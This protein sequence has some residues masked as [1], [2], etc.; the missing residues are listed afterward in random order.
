MKQPLPLLPLLLAALVL[1]AEPAQALT[2]SLDKSPYVTLAVYEGDGGGSGGGGTYFFVVQEEAVNGGTGGGSGVNAS[3]SA[4]SGSGSDS[5]GDGGAGGGNRS[6]RAQLLL[7][8]GAAGGYGDDPHQA[9]EGHQRD[10]FFVFDPDVADGGKNFDVAIPAVSAA[11]SSSVGGI[12]N[13]GGRPRRRQQQQ[14]QLGHRQLLDGTAN[15]GDAKPIGYVLARRCP[16]TWWYDKARTGGSSSHQQHYYCPADKTHCYVQRSYDSVPPQPLC[17]S[18]EKKLSS[19]TQTIWPVV[20]VWYVLLATCL[21]CTTPGRN[22]LDCALAAVLPC[23]NDVVIKIML[24]RNPDRASYLVRRFYWRNRERIEQR[25][26]DMMSAQQDRGGGRRDNAGGG[27]GNGNV[28]DMTTTPQPQQQNPTELRLR[29]RI[30]RDADLASTAA[31]ADAVSSPSSPAGSEGEPA[32]TGDN[33]DA[34]FSSGADGDDSAQ[35]PPPPTEIE[36][37]ADTDK[38]PLSLS[39]SPAAAAAHAAERQV[40]G[41]DAADSEDLTEG[42]AGLACT[43]CFVP[44]EDGDRVGAL[45]CNH[46]VSVWKRIRRKL[47]FRF[48]LLYCHLPGS[49]AGY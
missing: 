4:I 29:T 31:A 9:E 42:A 32:V 47:P 45:P 3:G 1:K 48:L 38:K 17:L 2:C 19:V 33:G 41:V 35:S 12:N 6:R 13:G 15:D 24:R 5:V 36:P 10:D 22:A 25:Y 21:V 8:G 28:G 30:Y 23:W 18:E 37:V 49:A 14:K 46:T 39:S 7:R 11:A 34:C 43:I 26:R 40:V 44:L 20:V 27:D 16:C